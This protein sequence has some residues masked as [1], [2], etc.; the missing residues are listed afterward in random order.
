LRRDYFTCVFLACVA[1]ALA[2]IWAEPLYFT[3]DAIFPRSFGIIEI[4]LSSF[5]TVFFLLIIPVVT[6]YYRKNW[7]CVGLGA[8][9]L[10]AYI[11]HWFYPAIAE[12]VAADTA[13]VKDVILAY[14]FRGMY[15]LVNAPFAATSELVGN[16]IASHLS[17]W[18]LPVAIA[19][20]LLMKYA[21]FCRQAYITEK[22]SPAAVA[23]SKANAPIHSRPHEKRAEPEVIGTVISAPAKAASPVEVQRKARSARRKAPTVIN[24][25]QPI[26]KQSI[27]KP[28]TA[29]TLPEPKKTSDD[30]IHL[31]APG[32]N[33][34]HLGPPSES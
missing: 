30:V 14:L 32:S 31:G 22:L 28:D 3:Y 4:I 29:G 21:R 13:G 17:M 12:K 10:L 6:T 24:I 27:Q 15:D 9:G 1:G 5:Y 7:V 18:I 23:Q 26:E 8:Y 20:P 19:C 33:P 16:Y 34:I 2:F 11:P 25:E